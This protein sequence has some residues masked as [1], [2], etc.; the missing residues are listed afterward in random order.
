MIEQ[1]ALGN[2]YFINALRLICSKPE[3]IKRVLVSDKFASKGLYTL[4]FCKAGKWRY[5]HI[6]DNIPCRQSGKVN[7]CRNKNPNE[8][9]AMLIEK[10]YAKLHGCY[11]A[12][13]YGL[14]EKVL[15]D[16][17][18]SSPQCIRLETIPIQTKCDQ[19]WDILEKSLET[20][21]LIGCLRTIPD[22]YTENPTKRKGITLH[23]MYE[24]VD[25]YITS[26]EP[27]EDLDGITVGLICVRIL[28]VKII[29]SYKLYY[30]IMLLLHVK[31]FIYQ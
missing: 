6:D 27:T 31:Y 26:A 8:I 1:G 20:K 17:C 21:Q 22:P 16:F 29:L 18:Y 19:V 7:F 15:H 11:E 28:Q 10:A 2:K 25:L 30:Y 5:V 23:M 24:V 14:V 12:I 13:A 4:K 3:F 9:F